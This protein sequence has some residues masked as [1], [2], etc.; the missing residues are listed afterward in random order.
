MEMSKIAVSKINLNL[1]AKIV[2]VIVA[3]D[4]NAGL[5]RQVTLRKFDVNK[6]LQRAAITVTFL[7]RL[8][9]FRTSRFMSMN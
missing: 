5:G 3:V 2:N 4:A 8:K 7:Y 1:I 6:P 9:T